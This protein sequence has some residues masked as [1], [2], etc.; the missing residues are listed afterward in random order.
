[1][2]P[3]SYYRDKYI[4]SQPSAFCPGCGGGIILNAFV[5]AIDDLGLDRE[6][7]LAVSGIGCSAWIPSPNFKGDTL[8]TTHGRAIAYATGAKAFNPELTTVV[9]T[10]DG[11]GAG[12]GGNHLIHAARR[13]IDL[14]VILVNNMSY[15]M[16]GGQIAPTTLHE[17]RTV[18]SPYGNPESPFNISD[19]VMGAGA[20]YVAKWSTY[21][22]VELQNSI[23]EAITHK[24]FGF[25]EVL[26]QCPTQQRRIFDLKGSVDELPIRLMEMFKESTYVRD[27]REREEYFYAVPKQSIE[28]AYED[29]TGILDNTEIVDHMSLGRVI[30][31]NKNLGDYK[32]RVESLD[33]IERTAGSREEKIEL[34]IFHKKE[35]PEFTDSLQDIIK[36]ARGE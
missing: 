33:S 14:T 15:A 1:M 23:K 8:H 11:D 29:I 20:S 17:E 7:V 2:K 22:V 30:R 12:I 18:T 35:R 21:H 36:R 5:R 28:N 13:N 16:T 10:G 25:I 9:F 6:K 24:G 34:G 3:L 26:S 31:V 27:R 32:E 4:R 19:L